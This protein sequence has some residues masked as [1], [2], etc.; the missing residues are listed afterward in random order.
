M[1]F[2]G[3]KT[4]FLEYSTSFYE[5]CLISCFTESMNCNDF[6]LFDIIRCNRNKIIS[7]SL[8]EFDMCNIRLKFE[9][10]SKPLLVL[11]RV[12]FIEIPGILDF[13]IESIFFRF[14]NKS[15]CFFT[16]GFWIF[17][18]QEFSELAMGKCYNIIDWPVNA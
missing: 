8:L 12:F 11:F 4:Y 18:Y 14:N 13:I 16:K 10:Y 3:I 15:F 6:V 17:P 2:F 5:V 1:R 7:F 9:S